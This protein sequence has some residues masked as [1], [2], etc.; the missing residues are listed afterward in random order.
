MV[1]VNGK[2]RK[3]KSVQKERRKI[4]AISSSKASGG[5]YVPV[6]KLHQDEERS[7]FN[8]GESKLQTRRQRTSHRT[9]ENA[10]KTM[11]DRVIAF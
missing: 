8:S 11:I 4:P 5:Q 3:R 6:Q 7:R 1:F 10:R 9:M 2:R